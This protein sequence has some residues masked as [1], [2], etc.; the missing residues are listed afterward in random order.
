MPEKLVAYNSQNYAGTSGSGLYSWKLHHDDS[1]NSDI[2]TATLC[3]I[4]KL[5]IAPVI[6][7]IDWL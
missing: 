5:T 2:V 7:N 3:D 4:T 1:Y 6:L